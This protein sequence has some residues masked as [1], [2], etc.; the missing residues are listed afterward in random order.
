MKVKTHYI[1]A[2]TNGKVACGRKN[3]YT[4]TIWKEITCRRCLD[5]KAHK[6]VKENASK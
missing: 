4:T 6:Q 1:I 5:T 2:G 3:V